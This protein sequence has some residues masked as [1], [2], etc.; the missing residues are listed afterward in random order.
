MTAKELAEKIGKE[1]TIEIVKGLG[2]HVRIRDARHVFNRT[3]L[4]I[5]PVAGEGMTWVASDRVCVN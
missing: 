4:Q 3:D 5:E 2:I 1:A